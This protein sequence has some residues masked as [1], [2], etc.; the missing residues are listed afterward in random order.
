MSNTCAH[1]LNSDW[2]GITWS[3]WQNSRITEIA[4][5]IQSSIQ[6]YKI[7]VTIK[8]LRKMAAEAECFPLSVPRCLHKGAI[9]ATWDLR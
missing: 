3:E 8:N 1:S 2:A 9:F 5:F 7:L 4:E 6:D